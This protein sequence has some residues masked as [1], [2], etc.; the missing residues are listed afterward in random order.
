MFG[1]FFLRLICQGEFSVESDVTVFLGSGQLH[2]HPN[3]RYDVKNPS[4][5]STEMGGVGWPPAG[6]WKAQT[7]TDKLEL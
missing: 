3:M 5:L 7:L 6:S 2:R 4:V 1:T